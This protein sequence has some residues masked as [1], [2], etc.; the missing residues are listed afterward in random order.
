MIRN[1]KQSEGSFMMS[2]IKDLPYCTTEQLGILNL[3][4]PYLNIL[5]SRY[6]NKGMLIRL[7]KGMYVSREYLEGIEKRNQRS[8]YDEFISG[9]LYR[10]SYLSFDYVLYQHNLITEMPTNYTCAS[11]QKTSLFKNPLGSYYYHSLKKELFLGYEIQSFNGGKIYKARKAKALFDFLYI[12]KNTLIHRE[13]LEEL[14]LNLFNL[15]KKD[16]AELM[17]YNAIAQS[18]KL[19]WILK[20][21]L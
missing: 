17:K 8:E 16:K 7:K 11:T 3:Q 13:S 2:L 6:T 21:L 15:T 14:R 1:R 12:R 4:K 18:K 9:V 10:P 19:T 20:E 5:L